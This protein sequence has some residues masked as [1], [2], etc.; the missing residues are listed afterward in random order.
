MFEYTFPLTVSA[1]FLA[2]YL[3]STGFYNP[4]EDGFYTFREGEITIVKKEK[5]NTEEAIALSVAVAAY[6]LEFP[7]LDKQREIRKN[8]EFAQE[9]IVEFT[10]ENALLG[11]DD[12]EQTK[13]VIQETKG[14]LDSLQTGFLTQAIKEIRLIPVERLDIKF[15][16]EE[17]LLRFLNK[18]EVFLAMRPTSSLSRP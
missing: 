3:R 13:R 10:A 18:I 1:A 16:T 5:L 14:I 2:E 15:L 17:R 8:L 11:I 7:K 9:L 12:E 6:V 4:F